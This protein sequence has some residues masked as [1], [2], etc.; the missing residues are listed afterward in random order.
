M[1][2]EGRRLHSSVTLREQRADGMTPAFTSQGF[3]KPA[4]VTLIEAGRYRDCLADAR[5]AKQY[6]VPVNAEFES[7]EALDMAAG[8]LD[9]GRA[10][11]LLE[12]GLYV[13]DLWYLNY[14][15]RSECG[16][17]GVTRYA[18]FW[19][20]K[21]RLAAPLAPMRFDDTLYHLLGDGLVGLTA[22]RERIPDSRTYGGRS[23][24]STLVPGALVEGLRLAS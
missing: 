3:L 16:M 21:G 19:V 9:A 2:V 14:T 15:D 20:E 10:A 11:A 1:V 6:G 17:T 24:R 5:G 8:Q 23:T 4:T 18:S 7:P 22:Q 13:S 12:E